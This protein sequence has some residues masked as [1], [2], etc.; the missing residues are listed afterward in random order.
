MVA[1]K[2]KI[3]NFPIY[4]DCCCNG[5]VGTK[6]AA[7]KRSANHNLP[8]RNF[9]ISPQY[10]ERNEL[11]E[12]SPVPKDYHVILQLCGGTEFLSVCGTIAYGLK[13]F[14]TIHVDGCGNF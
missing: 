14:H 1:N 3:N 8:N 6:L 7:H 10:C 9:H 2:K 11:Y 5:E 12:W 13:K 4:C